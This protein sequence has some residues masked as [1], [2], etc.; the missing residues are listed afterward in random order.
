VSG[1]EFVDETRHCFERA[2]GRQGRHE[3]DLEL[4]SSRAKIV[5]AGKALLDSFGFAFEHVV[6]PEPRAP[7]PKDALTVFLWD[8]A[9]SGVPPP[10]PPWSERDFLA[11]GE[12]NHDF[13]D[14]VRMSFRIDS[15]VLSVFVPGT[16]T[17]F[18]WVRDPAGLPPWEVAA[19]VRPIF[20]WWA[21]NSGR[22]LA[23]GAAVGLDRGAVLLGARGGSGKSTTA[24]ACLEAGMFYLGDDYVLLEPGRPC[25]VSSLYSTA[26]LVPRNLDARL[27]RLRALV[28]GR[29]DRE[30]DKVTLGL[31]G[32][33]P[34]L[35][36][37]SLPLLA[38]VVPS[39]PPSG[40][41]ALRPA[42][43]AAALAALAPTTVF[44]LPNAGAAAVARL[45]EFVSATPRYFLELDRNLTRNVEAIRS[46]IEN[47]DAA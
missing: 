24:L 11:R 45:G 14:R 37:R 16:N 4:G 8:S 44:Q 36:A 22:Q 10:A 5:C 33:F 46:L 27:P 3:L 30:Q 15:G 19:P 12:I 42:P 28:T 17:A 39:V 6:A 40:Q 1:A 21:E 20:A 38:I 41:L 34:G 13:G 32:A 18:C 26:K 25:I 31:H 23:H 47:E 29:H 43:A 35:I 9:S 7:P 2:T